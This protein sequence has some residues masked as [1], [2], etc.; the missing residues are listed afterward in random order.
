MSTEIVTLSLNKISNQKY[1]ARTVLGQKCEMDAPSEEEI[2]AYAQTMGNDGH[3]DEVKRP[4]FGMVSRLR[5]EDHRSLM[6]SLRQNLSGTVEIES[7]K[8]PRCPQ[9]TVKPATQP[10]VEVRPETKVQPPVIT[11]KPDDG[12]KPPIKIKP[13]TKRPDKPVACPFGQ[14][15]DAKAKACVKSE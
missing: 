7:G 3:F 4:F 14:V 9:K 15:Y 10:V 11:K 1:V 12:K 5:I 8:L 6:K 2:T 13:I